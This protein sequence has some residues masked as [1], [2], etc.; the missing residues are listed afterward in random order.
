MYMVCHSV[1]EIEVNI[2][3]FG[4]G[5]DVFENIYPLV[6]I[7]Q[8]WSPVFGGP[9]GMYPDANLCHDI[10]GLGLMVILSVG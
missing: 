5:L 6:F 10:G 9:N 8:Q 2:F 4:V 7:G 1:D 3:F